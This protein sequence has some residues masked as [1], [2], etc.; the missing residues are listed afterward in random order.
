[1][2]SDF[3]PNEM[4]SDTEVICSPNNWV[5]GLSKG[6]EGCAFAYV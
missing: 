2:R 3:V 1:M 4:L 6:S 5:W